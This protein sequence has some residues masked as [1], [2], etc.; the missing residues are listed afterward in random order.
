M[1]YVALIIGCMVHNLFDE[2]RFFPKY[3]EKE[4]TAVLFG[5]LIA[6]LLVGRCRLNPG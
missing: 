4:L 2:D 1:T 3:P 5:R 6:H